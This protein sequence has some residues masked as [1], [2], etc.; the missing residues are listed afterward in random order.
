MARRAKKIPDIET[1]HTI[2]RDKGF[3][4]TPQRTAVHSAM[5]VLGHAGVDDI[6]EFI[7]DR[8]IKVKVT[9]T[10]IYNILSRMADLGIYNRMCSGTNK[11]LFD[12][13]TGKHVHL[14]DT[15]AS[16]YRDIEDDEL[17]SM[18]ESH[19]K[20]KQFRRYR[21]D[22]FDIQILCHPS[23]KRKKSQ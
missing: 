16:E 18:V 7:E 9:R 21:M 23:R 20:K 8:G 19:L 6:M 10:S 2:L 13:N 4:V 11:M 3:R 14:F 5:L 22:R 12:V 17:V 1:F 15:R